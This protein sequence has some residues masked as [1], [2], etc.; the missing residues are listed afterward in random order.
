MRLPLTP[1][2]LAAL[3]AAGAALAGAGP[4]VV[5]ALPAVAAAVV[6][7]LEGATAGEPL[8]PLVRAQLPDDGAVVAAVLTQLAR[9]DTDP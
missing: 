7:L 1:G 2:E 3:L 8:P 9:E 5:A 6:T 4:E